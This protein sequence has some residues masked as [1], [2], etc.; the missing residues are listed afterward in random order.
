VGNDS[1]QSVFAFLRL[2][3]GEKPVVA[4]FNFTPVPRYG[5]RVGV[6][7]PGAYVELINTDARV[8]GGS[9]VGNGGRVSAESVPCHG[10]PHS[11]VLTLPPLA[12]LWLRPE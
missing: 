10:R 4:V 1:E 7:H 2:S 5:Y 3:E 11:L 12:A 8:Y 6:P 9:D